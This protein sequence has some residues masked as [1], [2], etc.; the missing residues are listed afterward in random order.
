MTQRAAPKS[1]PKAPPAVRGSR[2]TGRVTIIDV[3][4]EAGVSPMTV[5]RALKNP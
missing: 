1:K 3:A 4:A 2:A 5:S